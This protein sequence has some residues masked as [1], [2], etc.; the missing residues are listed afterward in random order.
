M[1]DG[2]DKLDKFIEDESQNIKPEEY[3]SQ[4]NETLKA[5]STPE[6][7]NDTNKSEVAL[8]E[9]KSD[10]KEETPPADNL[11]EAPKENTNSSFDASKAIADWAKK[12]IT[13]D[14]AIGAS[15]ALYS[16]VE[17]II[18]SPVKAYESLILSMY[19]LKQ[20]EKV[21]PTWIGLNAVVVALLVLRVLTL[22]DAISTW[23]VSI[24][25]CNIV[26]FVLFGSNKPITFKKE[27]NKNEV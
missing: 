4:I 26:V 9:K 1:P 6:A 27:K 7:N 11:G 19:N 8:E 21:I 12:N 14:T 18:K 24:L 15:L 13:S 20:R 17:I 3:K 16:I 22:G 2:L 23:V 25:I 10:T 5:E